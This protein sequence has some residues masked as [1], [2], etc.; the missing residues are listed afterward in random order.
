ENG[1]ALSYF[2]PLNFITTP[3]VIKNSIILRLFQKLRIEL[4]KNSIVQ[5]TKLL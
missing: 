4:L 1:S 5:L 2:N 3:D